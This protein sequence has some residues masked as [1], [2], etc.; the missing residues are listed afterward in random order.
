MHKKK[1]KEV[2]ITRDKDIGSSY[3]TKKRESDRRHLLNSKKPIPKDVDAIANRFYPLSKIDQHTLS[4]MELEDLNLEKEDDGDKR[5]YGDSIAMAREKGK[6][7]NQIG[8]QV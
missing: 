8:R 3:S 7:Q 4:L 6:T 2:V 1:G 5:D